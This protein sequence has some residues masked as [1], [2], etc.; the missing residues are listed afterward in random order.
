MQ[1]L[2]V[3]HLERQ[4]L[5]GV[6][7]ADPVSAAGL[8]AGGVEVLVGLAEVELARPDVVVVVVAE[9]D[10]E[11]RQPVV[12]VAQHGG[13]DAFEVHGVGDAEAHAFIRE[14]RV[15][16]VQVHARRLRL[17]VVEPVLDD[18]TAVERRAGRLVVP[19]LGQHQA[20]RVQ[21]ALE[22]VLERDIGVANDVDADLVRVEAVLEVP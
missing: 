9:A 7:D 5:A 2:A 20:H 3:G 14:D 16:H 17:F 1:R 10:L 12:V 21:V 4:A 18:V 15:G 8:E 19:V 22:E 6:V 13:D 11:G